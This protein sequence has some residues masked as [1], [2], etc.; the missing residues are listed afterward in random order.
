MVNVKGLAGL[1]RDGLEAGG[2]LIGR[3]DDF[4]RRAAAGCLP[5]DLAGPAAPHASIAS[6]D[7][8]SG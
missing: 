4:S 5:Q 3:K 8:D 7:Q 1:I 6:F 2:Y